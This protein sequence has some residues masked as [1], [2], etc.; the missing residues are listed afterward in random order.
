MTWDDLSITACWFRGVLVFRVVIF[1]TG[2][3]SRGRVFRN[4]SVVG[5]LGGFRCASISVKVVSSVLLSLASYW[6][7]CFT[8]VLWC[9]Q[10]L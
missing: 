2:F 5:F 10:K 9:V 4:L 3:L 6:C 7:L 8:H 1:C